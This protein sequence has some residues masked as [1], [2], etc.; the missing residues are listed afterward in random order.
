MF[1]NAVLR[2]T[3]CC[4]TA[5]LSLL[6]FAGCGSKS[7]PVVNVDPARVVG[8]WEPPDQSGEHI[9]FKQD[10]TWESIVPGGKAPLSRGTWRIEAG[11]LLFGYTNMKGLPVDTDPIAYRIQAVEEKRMLLTL[12]SEQ[13]EEWKRIK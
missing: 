10:G 3:L 6:V 12:W 8:T 7:D 1:L 11:K 4:V 2:S 9:H 13:A 5:A